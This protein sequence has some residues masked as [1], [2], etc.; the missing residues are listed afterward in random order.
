MF[1]KTMYSKIYFLTALFIIITFTDCLQSGIF[2]KEVHFANR[3][4]SNSQ[5]CEYAFD[6]KDTSAKYNLIFLLKHTYKYPFGNIW[7][8]LLNTNP[9]GKTDTLNL[10]VPLALP[11]DGEWLGR[12]FNKI[13]EHRMNIGPN[14][15]EM[16]FSIPGLYKVKII[17]D[18]RLNPLPEVLSTGLAVEKLP[19]SFK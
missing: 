5:I 13:V 17:Q 19:A 11:T 3:Q 15:S 10:E 8:Q 16:K 2:Q 9:K 12:R 7:L 14:G 6:I 18:M 1:Y 4:W